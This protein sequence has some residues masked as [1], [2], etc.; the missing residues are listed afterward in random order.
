MNNDMKAIILAKNAG[1]GFITHEDWSS[2]YFRIVGSYQ[3]DSVV[4]VKGEP[5]AI[6]A[7]RVRVNGTVSSVEQIK[8]F[9]END[10]IAGRD[11][12]IQMLDNEKAVLLAR[13]FN[14]QT[15]YDLF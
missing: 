15:I 7:W 8:T 12:D 10:F 9:V 4:F 2:L 5:P 13:Q 3:G 11:Q 6:E 14:L 1:K